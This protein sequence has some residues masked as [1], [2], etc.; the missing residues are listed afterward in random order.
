MRWQVV[1]DV[2]QSAMMD[3]RNRETRLGCGSAEFGMSD[4]SPF[5]DD[6][7][8]GGYIVDVE[9]TAYNQRHG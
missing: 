3:Q 6:P 5:E 8:C 1:K 9:N 2:Q 7:T 4:A